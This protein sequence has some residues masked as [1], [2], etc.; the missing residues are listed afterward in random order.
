[1]KTMLMATLGYLLVTFPLGFVW[2][3][4]LFRQVYEDFGLYRGAPVIPLGVLSMVIQ[5]LV[6]AYLYPRCRIPGSPLASAFKFFMLMAL[7]FASGTVIALAAKTQIANLAGW[8]GYNFAFT[9]L[10]FTLVALVFA[11]VFRGERADGV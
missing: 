4:V 1:M 2:H 5:G 9:F 10:H 11:F 7:F 6:L 8:F 3:L